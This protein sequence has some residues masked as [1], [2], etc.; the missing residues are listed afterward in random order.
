MPLVDGPIL[1]R[2]VSARDLFARARRALTKDLRSWEAFVSGESYG[3][4]AAAWTERPCLPGP[5]R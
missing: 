5:G 3:M 1:I 4:A 2:M